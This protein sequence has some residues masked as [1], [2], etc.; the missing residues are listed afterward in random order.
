ME[1][2][3]F[4]IDFVRRTRRILTTYNGEYKLSNLINCTLGLIMLPYENIRD[5]QNALQNPNALWEINIDCISC[6]PGLELR[7]FNPI[8][9][10][11]NGVIMYYPKTLKVLL[12]KIRNG[13]AHQHIEPVNKNGKFIGVKIYNYFDNKYKTH[14]DLDVQFTRK[15]LQNFALFIA[16]EYLKQV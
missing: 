9:K 1:I 15:Q 5:C 16:D 10:I 11:K 3:K 4:D 12:Q 8:K 7:I 14:M 13:L 6:L 2:K